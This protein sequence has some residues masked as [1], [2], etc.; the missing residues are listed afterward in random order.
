MCTAMPRGV[1][2]RTQMDTCSTVQVRASAGRA[3]GGRGLCTALAGVCGA[4]GGAK[5]LSGLLQ[6]PPISVRYNKRLA[7]I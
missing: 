3:T 7:Q 6:P 5:S 1:K 4:G 2:A